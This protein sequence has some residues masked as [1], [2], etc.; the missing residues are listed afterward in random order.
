MAASLTVEK[1]LTW[2]RL[3][4]LEPRLAEL[5]AEI[6]R[7]KDDKR[8]SEFCANGAWYG[9]YDTEGFKPRFASLVGFEAKGPA[10]LK[11]MAAYDLAYEKLYQALPNCRNCFCI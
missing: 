4:E 5:L 1:P 11:T 8:R 10:E 3:V 6:R 9:T 7:V 2:A